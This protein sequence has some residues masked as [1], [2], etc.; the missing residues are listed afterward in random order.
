MPNP[1]ILVTWDLIRRIQDLDFG[2]KIVKSS[3]YKYKPNQE[4]TNA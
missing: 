2:F 1:K 3:N 4:V